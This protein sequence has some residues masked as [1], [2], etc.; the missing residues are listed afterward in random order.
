M[1]ERFYTPA[2]SFAGDIDGLILLILAFT[3]FWFV[4]AE[5]V[6]FWLIIKFRAKDG[7]KSQYITGEQKS[8][9]KWVSLPH[10]LVLVCDIFILVGTLRVWMDVKL[11]MPTP[12]AEIRV[13]GQQWAWSFVHPGKDGKID[14]DD[15]IRTV[16]ELHVE[17]GKTYRFILSSSDVLHSFSVPAFRLKQDAVPGREINGWFKPTIAGTYDIQCAEICG[18]AHGIMEARI[19]VDTPEAHAKWVA[20]GGPTIFWQGSNVKNPSGAKSA[21]AAPLPA[22]TTSTLAQAL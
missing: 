4:L 1:F 18:V 15:D 14:T 19:V 10:Y 12:D 9:K 2:S 22:T 20:A 13:N 16:E 8:E 5:L 7:V 3:G 6:F 17:L 11:T 21:S